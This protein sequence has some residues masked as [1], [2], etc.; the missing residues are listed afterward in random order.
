MLTWK[1]L[2]VLFVVGSMAAS[3]GDAF[4]VHTQTTFYPPEGPVLFFKGVPFWIP[5]LFGAA[6]AFFGIV[7]EVGRGL[8]GAKRFKQ[9]A[10]ITEV[11]IAGVVYLF[12]HILS[13]Y[14]SHLSFP[15]PLV[16]LALPVVIMWRWMDKSPGGALFCLF[17]GVVGVS[18][19]VLLV[20]LG[21]F[22]FSDNANEL[23]GVASWLICIYMAGT[24]A[25]GRFVERGRPYETGET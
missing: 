3:V 23:F 7:Y 9:G 25:I 22:S 17:T 8:L 2:V 12:L 24:L 14:I 20:Q 16:L 10:N 5:F 15:L 1:K 18:A 4:H 6:S 13:G 21:I 19:E 11:M